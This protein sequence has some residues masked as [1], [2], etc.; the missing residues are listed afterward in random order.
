[1]MSEFKR[2]TEAAEEAFRRIRQA[3]AYE[4][5]VQQKLRQ[6]E[7][8]LREW[9]AEKN[10]YYN[11]AVEPLL[12]AFSTDV[13]QYCA[14]LVDHSY[15]EEGAQ[16][17]FIAARENFPDFR[18]DYGVSSLRTW[19]FKIAHSLCL[20]ELK[21]RKRTVQNP[22]VIT[23]IP[24]TPQNLKRKLSSRYDYYERWAFPGWLQRDLAKLK[25]DSDRILLKMDMHRGLT[26][27]DIAD[28]LGVTAQTV[29]KR[30]ERAR[31]RLD[32]IW[33]QENG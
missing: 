12:E 3:Q 24:A 4:K 15:A 29:R 31:K 33:D 2:N 23:T 25:F 9:E 11:D 10:K 17:T 5:Q 16:D 32:A 13:I 26:I 14:L 27:Q 20:K 28:I 19:L 8:Q 6:Y 30:L 22:A 7:A 21:R 1:M 18:G